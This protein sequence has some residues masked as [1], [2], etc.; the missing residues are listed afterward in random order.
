M[1]TVEQYIAPKAIRCR[2]SA[3]L[4]AEA[5]KELAAFLS[6]VT[7]VHGQQHALAA[8]KHWMRALEDVCPP[9]FPSRECFRK[10]TLAA[11]V[12]FNC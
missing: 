12:S 3:G 4:F 2:P 1:M 9:A 8:A 5:E 10:V 11:A 6:A 7:A